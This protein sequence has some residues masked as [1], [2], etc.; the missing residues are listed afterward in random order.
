MAALFVSIHNGTA[1]DGLQAD[2]VLLPSGR[3]G[4][5]TIPRKPSPPGPRVPA[6]GRL[7]PVTRREDQSPS[8]TH[9]SHAVIPRLIY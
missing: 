3:G 6:A 2:G 8:L 4:G 5:E 9:S 7:S 1:P